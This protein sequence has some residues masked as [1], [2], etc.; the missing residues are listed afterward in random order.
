M[1][2]KKPADG[3]FLVLIVHLLALDL[4][5]VPSR[6]SFKAASRRGKP[7]TLFE[8]G[9]LVFDVLA[10]NR[11]EF[12]NFEFLRFG[13]LVLGGGVEVASSRRRFEL[14]FLSH[15]KSLYCQA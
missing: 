8:L 15:D 12:Q 10:H 11:V 14:Y 13:A 3:G 4:P 5:L 6:I 1:Q 2:N 9:F 7:Q